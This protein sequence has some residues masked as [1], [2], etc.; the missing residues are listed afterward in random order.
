MIS[1]GLPFT[2]VKSLSPLPIQS[3]VRSI[4]T[5][6]RPGMSRTCCGDI[7]HSVSTTALVNRATPEVL[8]RQVVGDI[9]A[10]KGS[11][12]WHVRRLESS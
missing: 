10:K 7:P 6:D 4:G 11:K 8:L 9:D 5:K 3:P 2:D 12:S 1:K